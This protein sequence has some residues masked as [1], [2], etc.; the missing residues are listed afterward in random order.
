MKTQTETFEAQQEK[1]QLIININT[2]REKIGVNKAAFEYL[3]SKSVEYLRNEQE[4]T[5]KHYNEALKNANP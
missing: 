4:T 5:I 3:W 1:Q 2:M